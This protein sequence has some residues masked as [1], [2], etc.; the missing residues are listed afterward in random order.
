MNYLA[1]AYLSFNKPEILVGNMISDFVKGKNK[2]NYSPGIQKGITLHRA[3]D[4]FTDD[5]P[6]TKAAKLFFRPAYRLYAGAF[7]DVAY[8][9]FLAIDRS[10][11]IL[12]TDLEK[13]S[14]SV[15]ETLQDNFS[16]LPEIFQKMLPYMKTQ[17]WLYNY[18]YKWGIE[19]GFRGLAN[20]AA[21]L[22]ESSIAFSI[23]NKHYGE[24]KEYYHAFFPEQKQFAALQLRN[25][26]EDI[27]LYP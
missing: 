2:F 19:K 8:D 6:A 16:F 18:Q 12:N 27:S 1:H 21:Y 3:I 7:I 14:K 20:R 24:L 11:F 25:L 26:L 13:F 23:F 4:Q 15:Y 10:E 5:H 9:H 17:N 22:N